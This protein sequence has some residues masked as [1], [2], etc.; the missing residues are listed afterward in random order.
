MPSSLK[1]DFIEPSEEMYVLQVHD[2]TKVL[3]PYGCLNSE[4]HPFRQQSVQS[5]CPPKGLKWNRSHSESDCSTHRSRRLSLFW[6][7]ISNLSPMQ[8]SSRKVMPQVQNADIE[9][10]TEPKVLQPAHEH[11]CPYHEMKM[12]WR[13]QQIMNKQY[14]ESTSPG[15]LDWLTKRGKSRTCHPDNVDPVIR[16]VKE[17]SM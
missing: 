16:M 13:R 6:K 4:Y 12:K 14:L 1:I 2:N 8:G 17:S 3:R 5:Q 9:T 7:S 10:S 15:W 11:T